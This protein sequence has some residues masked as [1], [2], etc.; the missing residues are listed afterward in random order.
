MSK[1]IQ[2]SPDDVIKKSSKIIL[3]IMNQIRPQIKRKTYSL[4]TTIP[5]KLK[6][7][8]YKIWKKKDGNNNRNKGYWVMDKPIRNNKILMRLKRPCSTTVPEQE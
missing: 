5:R 4:E 6:G 7:R 3:M 1:K 2:E 8:F